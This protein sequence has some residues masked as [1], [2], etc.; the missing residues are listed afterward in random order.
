[1]AELGRIEA[2]KRIACPSC[3]AVLPQWSS[4]EILASE[5]LRC[6]HCGQSVKL[7]DEVYERARQTR[8][9]GRNLDITG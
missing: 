9:L 1:M 7:P 8:Y 3:R 4:E 2:Q 5:Q 6:P